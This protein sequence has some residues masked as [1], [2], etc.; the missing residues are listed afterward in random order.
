MKILYFAKISDQLGKKQDKMNISD[1]IKIKDLVEILV[2]RNKKYSMVFKNISEIK[3]AVNCEY[4]SI[5]NYVSDEDELAIFPP[6][7]GG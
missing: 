2:K 5:N 1:K 3:F 6:V 4:V 7:T